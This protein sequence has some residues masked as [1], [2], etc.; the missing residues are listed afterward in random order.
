VILGR[1][2]KQAD[3]TFFTPSSECSVS[4]KHAQLILKSDGWRIIGISSSQSPIFVDGEQQRLHTE[5]PITNGTKI[6]LGYE[7]MGSAF[8]EFIEVDNSRSSVFEEPSLGVRK[9]KPFVEDEYKQTEIPV[10]D[11]ML[12]DDQDLV[13]DDVSDLTNDPEEFFNKYR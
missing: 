4:G 6:E 9:T 1:D 12:M 2:P 3:I 5:I 7:D 11:D 8:F 13:Q 10:N